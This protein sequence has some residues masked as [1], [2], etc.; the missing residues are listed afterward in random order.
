MPDIKDQPIF[1][2]VE[3]LVDGNRQ[4]HHAETRAQMPACLRHGIDHLVAQ[5]PGQLRQVAIVDVLEV[6]WEFHPVKQWCLW[7]SGQSFGLFSSSAKRAFLRFPSGVQLCMSFTS[8]EFQPSGKGTNSSSSPGTISK[9]PVLHSC[10]A[11]SMRSFDDE[12]KFHQMYRR[13]FSASPPKIMM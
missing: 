9:R 13:E 6:G 4:F 12:T 1:G 8:I 11:C 3:D 5:F 7:H 10:L 2:R